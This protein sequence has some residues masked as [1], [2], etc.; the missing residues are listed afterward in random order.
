MRSA[1][2]SLLVVPVGLMLTANGGPAPSDGGELDLA[3]LEALD[4]TLL[5]E[6]RGG[7]TMNGMTVSLGA[8]F[9]TFLEGE[10]VLRTTVSWRPEGMTRE[11]WASAAISQATAEQ[12]RD[13][14]LSGNGITMRVGDQSVYLANDNRTALVHRTDGGLQNMV[15]NT[16]S[17]TNIRQEADIT[18]DV[19]GYS[20]FGTAIGD[21]MRLAGINDAI[22]QAAL[23]TLP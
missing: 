14:V 22:D 10:L 19:A 6:Q 16:A 18:L 23:S 5:A 9:R 2:L 7:F 21:A 1:F 13:G 4:E 8:E 20:A 12:L 17:N 11:E 15:I 3:A